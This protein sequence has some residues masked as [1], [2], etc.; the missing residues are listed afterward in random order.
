MGGKATEIDSW[1]NATKNGFYVSATDAP[2]GEWWW[3]IVS[4]YVEGLLVQKVWNNN[5]CG[6]DKFPCSCERSYYVGSGWRPWEWVNPPMQL[7]VEYRTTERYLGKP[8]YVKCFDFG[9]LPNATMKT[10]PH[11]I[12]NVDTC[13]RCYGSLT[14]GDKRSLPY[15]EAGGRV[16]CFG[17]S[18]GVNMYSANNLSS[19]TATA[20]VWVT[21]T[22]D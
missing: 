6:A 3:G 17:D 14:S 7:G 12:A 18:Y 8:V 22:T 13:V 2:D 15:A 11:G 19:L 4:N 9:P 10:S 21:K 1:N 20:T 16:D 5:A